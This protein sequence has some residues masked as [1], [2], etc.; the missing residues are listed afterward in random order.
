MC[1]PQQII[2]E[3]QGRNQFVELSD[4]WVDVPTILRETIA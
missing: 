4:G 3:L 2:A 1:A